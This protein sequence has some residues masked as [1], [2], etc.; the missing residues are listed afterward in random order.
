MQAEITDETSAWIHAQA[1]ARRMTVGEV[2][3]RLV[4]LARALR[5]D[6][7]NSYPSEQLTTAGLGPREL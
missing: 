4:L 2:V 3:D 5:E 6:S 1:G 7:T